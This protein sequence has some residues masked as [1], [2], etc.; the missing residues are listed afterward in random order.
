[1]V[2]NVEKD[3]VLLWGYS[4]LCKEHNITGFNHQKNS[5]HLTSKQ[6]SLRLHLVVA[7]ARLLVYIFGLGRLLFWP[8][9]SDL[10]LGLTQ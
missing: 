8:H 9:R 10:G 3:D 2:P 5:S 6:T 1:M 7:I 4:S